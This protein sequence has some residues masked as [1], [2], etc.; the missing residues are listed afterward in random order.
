MKTERKNYYDVLEV[1]PTATLQEIHNAYTRTKNAYSGDAAALYSLMS[2]DES[3]KILEQIEEAYSILG[4]ADKRREY[5]LARGFNQEHTKEGFEK[6]HLSK[7][8]FNMPE[9]Q[10]PQTDYRHQEY[11]Q[12]RKKREEF[13]YQVEHSPR[14][15][16][17]VSKI[18]AANKFGLKFKRD[19]EF[20]Q[21]IENQTEFSGSFLKRIRQYKDVSIERMAE[22]TR[23]SKTY[24]KNIEEDDFEKLPAEVYARG[25]VYQ[26]AKCLKLNADLVATSYINYMKRPDDAQI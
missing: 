12:E 4:V 7:T 11:M 23:I 10:E 8:G 1:D 9:R 25:F 13:Q 5:D 18:Q 20:E 15:E 6:E 19:E 21:E 2:S 22:M 3:D 26:Y 17:E 16:A 14:R 24:I